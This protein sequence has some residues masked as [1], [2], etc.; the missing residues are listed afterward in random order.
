M[1]LIACGCICIAEE[2]VCRCGTIAEM[3]ARCSEYGREVLDVASALACL[4]VVLAA[5]MVPGWMSMLG[6]REWENGAFVM[7]T[8]K[9][10]KSGRM[11]EDVALWFAW[12]KWMVRIAI[13]GGEMSVAYERLEC[14]GTLVIATLLRSHVGRLLECVAGMLVRRRCRMGCWGA[15]TGGER[16]I[17]CERLECIGTLANT[18]HARSLCGR[19]S[20][21]VAGML[22]WLCWD[23]R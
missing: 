13:A 11:L 18:T 14:I 21:C 1:E 23:V 6:E 15:A 16:S 4:V 12:L 3:S 17:A 20:E 19:I 22:A 5:A 2:R 10:T 9:C 8:G 7:S